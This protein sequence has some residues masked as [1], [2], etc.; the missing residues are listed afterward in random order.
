MS[1]SSPRN[2]IEQRNFELAFHQDFDDAL[3]GAAQRE[4]I[5]RTGRNQAHA[6]ASAQG[7]ELV[8]D[9]DDLGGAMARNGIFHAV[10]LVLI[11]DCLPH[12]IGLA[13]GAGVEA[14]DDALQFG[15]F[16]DELRGEIAFEHLGGALREAIAAQF[17]GERNVAFGLFEIGAEFGL[18]GDVGEILAAV[19]R[20][21]FSDRSP[22]RSGRR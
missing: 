21:S 8:G 14:A 18:E 13:L 7:I 4:G 10:R 15:E 2:K 5:A 12:G 19:D 20:A 22:R 17:G 9:G 3:R 11:V 16:L 1:G 6:E